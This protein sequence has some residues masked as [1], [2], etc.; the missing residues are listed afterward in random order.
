MIK[1]FMIAGILAALASQAAAQQFIHGVEVPPLIRGAQPDGCLF[2]SAQFQER[3]LNLE[4]RN[5]ETGTIVRLRVKKD[6]EGKKAVDF[7]FL[8]NQIPP[9]SNILASR[10]ILFD[11]PGSLAIMISIFLNDCL[12]WYDFLPRGK[13]ESMLFRIGVQ[14]DS[15]AT[16]E[17]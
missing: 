2:S 8:F 12:V 17:I 4:F 15:Q 10:V 6:F 9:R 16:G 14:P 11:L 13:V 7:V 3:A 5:I 1:S